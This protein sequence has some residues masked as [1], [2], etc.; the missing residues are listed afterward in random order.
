[1]PASTRPEH[2]REAIPGPQGNGFDSLTGREART[3]PRAAHLPTPR[4]RRKP[5]LR[6]QTEAGGTIFQDPAPHRPGFEFLR[7]I[8]MAPVAIRDPLGSRK[9]RY[10]RRPLAGYF[11]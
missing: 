3:E 5:S 2:N 1:M 6:V 4:K 10:P 11:R 8:E 9:V 7:C